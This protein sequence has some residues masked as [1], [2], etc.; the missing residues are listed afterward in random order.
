[1][2]FLSAAAIL[3]V[4]VVARQ[5]EDWLLPATIYS[6]ALAL[7]LHNSLVSDYIWGWDINT[8]RFSAQT[9]LQTGHWDPNTSGNVNA[10]L[11]I[12]ML[13][14]ALA[15]LT[16]LQIHEVFKFI[17]PLAFAFV[18]L[19]VYY[20]AREQ[21]STR[22]AFLA[23]MFL[24]MSSVFFSEMLQVARQEIAE[25][26]LASAILL[27]CCARTNIV[28]QSLLL[29]AFLAAVVVSHYGLAYIMLGLL[30]GATVLVL[31]LPRFQSRAQRLAFNVNL[32]ALF[33]VVTLGWYIYASGGSPFE[34]I[35]KIGSR[36]SESLFT[37]FLDPT[38]AQ[39]VT[40]LVSSLSVQ[41]EITRFLHLA[42]QLAITLGLAIVL[43]RRSENRFRT[44][45]L[46]LS[47]LAFVLL[48]AGIGVPYFASA[49]NT[50]R[51]YHISTL[52]LAP[53]FV[54]GLLWLLGRA[55]ARKKV[56]TPSWSYLAIAGFLGV[57]LLFNAGFVY[58]ITGDEPATAAFATGTDYPSFSVGERD[59]AAWASHDGKAVVYAD[60]YRS[61]LMTG[62]SGDNARMYTTNVPAIP[63]GDYFLEGN[64][65]VETHF[66][67]ALD[68]GYS[69]IRTAIDVPT[70]HIDGK[71]NLVY[72]NGQSRVYRA[73]A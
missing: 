28:R 29:I 67:R 45:Y 20:A 69:T 72:D 25:L 4:L 51:L 24:V 27:M 36:V 57:F 62:F 12:V 55:V 16:G 60:S 15:S 32:V 52:F 53:F 63:R 22:I 9:V 42:S 34:S 30:G 46:S 35:V 37:K 47:S 17:F 58:K 6:V 13:A 14:P 31:F 23:A 64:R 5:T 7:L 70:S 38:A 41:R 26:E 73:G 3:P 44:D 18:P 59:A 56:D 54:M 2:V 21:T 1:M 10:M 71:L 33:G 39:G 8:E 48:I 61:L 40:V 65:N 66:L 19:L 50:T 43:F 68:L 11:S 49:I